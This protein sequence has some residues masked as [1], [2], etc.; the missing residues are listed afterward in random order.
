ME[1]G[2]VRL[3]RD[4]PLDLL[5]LPLVA[6]GVD[7]DAG[8]VGDIAVDISLGRD[9]LVQVHVSDLRVVVDL[10]DLPVLQVLVNLLVELLVLLA[11]LLELVAEVE[12]VILALNFLVEAVLDEAVL[13]LELHVGDGGL[14]DFLVVCFQISLELLHFPDHLL[15]G[16]L[17]L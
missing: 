11:V 1:A 8:G 9:Y 17:N 2:G 6:P 5:A 3:A 13:E 10:R 15:Q 14:R 16:S 7:G 4:L 12:G